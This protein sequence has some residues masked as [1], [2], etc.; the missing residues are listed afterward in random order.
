MFDVLDHELLVQDSDSSLILT[1]DVQLVVRDVGWSLVVTI[2]RLW[3][4]AACAAAVALVVG[5]DRDGVCSVYQVRNAWDAL[6]LRRSVGLGSVLWR[7]RAISR[8]CA[9]L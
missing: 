3:A 5:H 6:G 7:G 2:D 4:F 9:W 8:R 1:T